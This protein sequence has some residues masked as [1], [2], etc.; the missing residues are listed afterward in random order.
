M[1]ASTSAAAA[2]SAWA[3]PSSDRVALL[4]TLANLPQHPESVPI[5]QL[6][7]VP[8]T[9]LHGLPPLDPLDFVR[10]IATARAADA[11]VV[12]AA[13]RRPRGHERRGAGAVLPRRRQLDLLRRKLLTTP[14][15]GRSHDHALFARL[16][17]APEHAAAVAGMNDR[18]RRLSRARRDARGRWPTAT[19]PARSRRVARSSA[20]TGG[21]RVTVDGRECAR[22]LQQRLPRA[23][24]TIRASSRRSAMPRAAGA[25]AAAPRTWSAVTAPN[26]TR[27]KKNSPRSPR[28][29]ARC[30]SPPATWPTSPSAPRWSARGDR[31]LEDQL[32]HASLLDAGLA[33][34]ARLRALSR[35]A[36]SP[37]CERRLAATARGHS[38]LVAT[39]GVFSMDGDVAPL[40]GVGAACARSGAWL[41]VDDAHGFGVLGANGARQPSRPRDSALDDVPVLMCTLGKAFGTFGAFVAG[42]PALIESLMQ[43]GAHLH[44]HDGAAAGGGRGH[45]RGAARDAARN[46]GAASACW[47]MQRA[48]AAA[49]R[50]L[51][52]QVAAVAARRSSR[53]CSAARRAALAASRA[54]LRPGSLGAGNPAADGAAGTF[55]PARDVFGR[56]HRRRR[57]RSWLDAL[58]RSRPAAACCRERACTSRLPRCG[59]DVVLLHGWALHG[60]MWGPWLGQA[61]GARAPAC[62]RPAGSRTLAVA[63]RDRGCRRTCAARGACGASRRHRARLVA[64]RDGGPRTG[65]RGMRERRVAGA[66]R[67]DAAL[68]GRRRIG[69]TACATT[70]STALR[71]GSPL[72]YRGHG[73]EFPR[74][75]DSRRRER[76]TGVARAAQPSS[77]RTA[78]RIARALAAGLGILRAVDLRDDLPRIAQPALVIAGERD[79]LTP[80]EA[81]RELATRLPSARFH[82]IERAGHA[83]FL[84]HPDE[85]LREVIPFLKRR[86]GETSPDRGRPPA[87]GRF[88]PSPAQAGQGTSAM[89]RPRREG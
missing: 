17:I 79:R 16:G 33:T 27:W 40:R 55:A 36:T 84:S 88:E 56:A 26:I 86:K 87:S 28:G 78:N 37:S 51:G 2:S 72:D 89:R 29:R 68:R 13:V 82:L 45:A 57:R 54:L 60:G 53:S 76:R 43:H 80:P 3:R 75:A 32:N 44:L 47:R 8:G 4:H 23:C 19:Q 14:N 5:N 38:T 85:V 31:V 30:C 62:R 24:A 25:S 63:R 18:R 42:S 20:R 22:V 46:R 74:T 15:P 59:P 1:P 21:A 61:R 49:A 70:C 12:R 83:P 9:P 11:E 50:D 58:Q 34:G 6:V 69:S 81:G 10:T 65:A 48:F 77:A 64:R 67:D 39:D 35:M 71:A 7:Q 73:A 41:M 52:L 66:G